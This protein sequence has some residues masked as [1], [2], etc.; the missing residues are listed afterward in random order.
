MQSFNTFANYKPSSRSGNIKMLKF[1]K[2]SLCLLTILDLAFCAKVRSGKSA[3]RVSRRQL[4]VKC[5]GKNSCV[6]HATKIKTDPRQHN[7]YTVQNLSQVELVTSSMTSLATNI[8]DQTAIISATFTTKEMTK[9][10]TQKPITQI[11]DVTY[12]STKAHKETTTTTALLQRSDSTQVNILTQTTNLLNQMDTKTLFQT[13]TLTESTT[14]ID[15]KITS[16]TISNPT[17]K[18]TSTPILIP[19]TLIPKVLPVCPTICSKEES[20][21]AKDGTLIDPLS[22]GFWAEA[23]GQSFVF[24]KRLANWEQNVDFCCKLNMQPIMLESSAKQECFNTFINGY[25]WKYNSR[26]WT[27]GVRSNATE[28][29]WCGSNSSVLNAWDTDEPNNLN[30]TENCIQMKI[31]RTY[32]TV[33]LSDKPCADVTAFACQGSPTPKPSCTSPTCPNYQCV[34]DKNFYASMENDPDTTYL[35]DPKQ[36]GH[37][38]DVGSR[39]YVF[40]LATNKKSFNDSLSAC[41]SIGVKLLSLHQDF[42]FETLTNASTALNETKNVFWTSATDTGCIGYAGYCSTNRLI[43]NEAKWASGQ[44]D[45][46]NGTK[47]C[48][49]V[50]VTQ[51][52]SLLFMEDCNKQLQYICEGRSKMGSLSAMVEEECRIPYHLS[53]EQVQKLLITK[54]ENIHDKCFIK[55]YGEGMGLLVN[56]KLK[57]DL[58]YA[59]M[60]TITSYDVKKLM[61]SYAVMDM[62]TNTTRGMDACDQ[63]AELLKCGQENSPEALASLMNSLETSMIEVPLPLPPST[64]I[65][66]NNVECNVYEDYKISFDLKKDNDKMS[67]TFGN[68]IVKHGCNKKYFLLSFIQQTSIAK[69]IEHCCSMGLRLATIDTKSE[70]DCLLAN[71]ITN[72]YAGEYVVAASMLGKIGRPIWCFSSAPFNTSWFGSQSLTNETDPTRYTVNLRFKQPNAIAVSYFDLVS[73]ALCQS[74]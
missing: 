66:P 61:E 63:A 34:K 71:N 48:V 28:L 10:I 42:M 19:T 68:G 11:D 17:T 18:F 38:I 51:S 30:K 4:I 6:N 8:F 27:Y 3:G 7:S 1:W 15:S 2:I 14:L 29:G 72:Y 65:C 59:Q 22:H 60:G 31:S 54:P 43:R 69:A 44:P 21:F 55:C 40:S 12:Y 49:A 9:E 67:T 73:L 45:S 52:S 35:R 53:K 39:R 33:F 32:S 64:A 37:W 13:T 24:G 25:N 26:Y 41:C 56:G 58:I 23:C 46:S 5:C 57:E 70:H 36:H 20:F 62:C 47:H 16:T 74:V 50:E